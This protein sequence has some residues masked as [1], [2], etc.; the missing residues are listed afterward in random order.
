M[1]KLLMI[2]VLFFALGTLMRLSLFTV[3]EGRGAVVLGWG[4]K[5]SAV[6]VKPGIWLKLPDPLERV[7]PVDLRRR[8]LSVPAI[9]PKAGD[10]SPAPAYDVVWR[11]AD[12][13]LWWS[14]FGND[15]GA[16]S[17]AISREVRSA[18][19]RVLK[20]L[21]ELGLLQRGGD[22]ISSRVR[23][24][25]EAGLKAQGI[26]LDA[27]R[28]AGIRPDDKTLK[29]M[30][31]ATSRAWSG[32]IQASGQQ[33]KASAEAVRRAADDKAS[34]VIAGAIDRARAVRQAAD[35][36][37]DGL[38][39]RLDGRPGLEGLSRRIAEGRAETLR[40]GKAAPMPA[41]GGREP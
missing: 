8:Q 21:P 28:L 20:D 10:E 13:G 4:G 17:E 35:R 18:S 24:G 40:A 25:A 27:V 7:L 41:A 39:G 9:D 30:V 5:L 1:K 6:R 16:A 34:R 26:A 19:A 15:E 38:Y 32:E 36:E 3:E 14:K 29:Q 23:S 22:L 37:A 31:E 12:P 33:E 2:F 11:V